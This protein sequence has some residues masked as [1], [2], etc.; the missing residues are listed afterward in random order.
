MN[1]R[2]NKIKTIFWLGWP[3]LVIVGLLLYRS[4]SGQGT[5]GQ[6][7]YQIHCASCHMAEGEGLRQLIPPL[8]QADYF[9]ENGLNMACLIRNGLNEPV[10]VNGVEY[11]RPMPGN[12]LLSPAE[13]TALIRYIQ[14]KWYP[15]LPEVKFQ[16]VEA[17]L[18]T[19]DLNE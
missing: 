2:R 11:N 10:W 12:T 16:E 6:K 19:C 3:L 4:F 14:Q 13:I 1:A 7:L 15:H 17:A 5:A 18:Q 8:R 9:V